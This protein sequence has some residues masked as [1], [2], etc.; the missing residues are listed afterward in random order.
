MK[1]W[2]KY[3]I[4]AALGFAAALILPLDS[5][6]E[7]AAL[8]FITDLIIRIGRYAL[9]PLLFFSGIMAVYRMRED[10]L[11]LRASLWTGGT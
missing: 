5:L 8:S 10:S 9:L 7:A 2:L 4:G 11:L 3:L 1:L 6:R